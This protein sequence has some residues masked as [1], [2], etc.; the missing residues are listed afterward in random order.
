MEVWGCMPLRK[1]GTEFPVEISLSPMIT[2]GETLVWSTIRDIT[3]RKQAE[4]QLSHLAAVVKS[5]DDA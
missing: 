2:G 3:E 5:S 4:A 1:D